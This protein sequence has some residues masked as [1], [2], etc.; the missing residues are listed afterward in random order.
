M[1][2]L[3]TLFCIAR[4]LVIPETPHH[5]DYA[6]LDII[7]GV[8]RFVLPRYRFEWPSMDWWN[9]PDFNAYLDRFGLTRSLMTRNKWMVNELLKLIVSI[10]GD[11]AECG[12]FEGATSL[13]DL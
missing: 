10:P 9:D 5:R 13:P 7:R 3:K 6:R 2:K 11:T 8:A 1:G 4:N 12:V